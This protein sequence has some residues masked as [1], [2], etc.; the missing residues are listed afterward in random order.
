VGAFIKKIEVRWADLDPNR[1]VSSTAFGSLFVEARFAYMQS[2]GFGQSEFQQLGIGPVVLWER[3]HYLR[4][5]AQRGDV[6]VDLRLKGV[7]EDRL[8][9][10]FAQSLFDRQ[11]DLAVY[12]E[13]TFGWLD[14]GARKLILPPPALERITN[15]LERADDFETLTKQDARMAGVPAQRKLDLSAL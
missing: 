14:L 2:Q 5:I 11:G 1:H 13:I 3:F 7:S 10:R 4:E 9:Y 15:L 8:I 6:F 12:A